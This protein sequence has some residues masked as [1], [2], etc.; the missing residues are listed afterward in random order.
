ML[1]NENYYSDENL[2]A[3]HFSEIWAAFERL[4]QASE[5]AGFAP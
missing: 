2:T 4:C 5:E 3:S 1:I